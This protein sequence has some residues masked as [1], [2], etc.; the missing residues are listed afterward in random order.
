[1]QTEF[2]PRLKPTLSLITR[3]DGLIY[4]GDL[5]EGFELDPIPF[6]PLL[7]RCT[8]RSSIREIATLL[9]QPLELIARAIEECVDLGIIE[10]LPFAIWPQSSMSTFGE[11]TGSLSQE[12]T[13]IELSLATHRASDGGLDEWRRRSEFNVVITGDTRITRN[14][15]SLICASGF[16]ETFLDIDPHTTPHIVAKDFNGLSVTLDDLGKN[17]SI[18]HKDLIRRNKF[19]HS[20]SQRSNPFNISNS[21]NSSYMP[22]RADLIIAT[23][24]P[25]LDAIAR[26]QSE[27]I[28]HIALTLPTKTDIEISPLITPG[29]TPCLQCIALHRRDAL[30]P[31]LAPL[32][33][34]P[35]SDLAFT[36]HTRRSELPAPSAA[37]IASLLT[38]FT[39][40]ICRGAFGATVD[41]PHLS[42]VIN[43]LAPTLPVQY[44]RWN[45]H[46]ECGCVD[47]QRRAL[48]R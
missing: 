1:M 47:V 17:K 14:L 20:S 29:I 9:H 40:D 3:T 41:Q 6:L 18:H 35:F 31:D 25:S 30:P 4:V 34:M 28:R 22:E 48:R 12:R 39:I 15:L 33:Y 13:L 26:W 44:R 32:A 23:S 45:F 5:S 7:R 2:F 27:G 11:E 16:R 38:T 46:P 37:L 36:D 42:Q 10:Q 8:G 21:S 19:T 24:P 43:L